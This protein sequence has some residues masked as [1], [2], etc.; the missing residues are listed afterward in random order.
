MVTFLP[1]TGFLPDFKV[2]AIFLAFLTFKVAALAVNAA[3]FLFTTTLADSTDPL[4]KL[5]SPKNTATTFLVVA[6]SSMKGIS[7]LPKGSVFPVI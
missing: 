7:R 2:T 4:Y 3:D 6:A 5:P 1:F